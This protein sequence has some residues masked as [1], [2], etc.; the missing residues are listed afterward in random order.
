MLNLMSAISQLRAREILDSRATPTL[1]V[2]ITLEDGTEAR[3]SVPS[4]ASTGKHEAFELRDG[5]LRR[6]GGKGVL[7]SVALVEGEIAS[8]LSGME[9]CEQAQLDANLCALDRALLEESQKDNQEDNNQENNRENNKASAPKSLLGAQAC[10]AVSLACARAA[11]VSLGIP[12]YRHLG[13]VQARTLPVPMMNIINGGAHANNA[14]EVQEFMLLPSGASD[15]SEALRMGVEC[16]AALKSL[17][18]AQGLSNSL[19]DEGGFAPALKSTQQALDLLMQAIEKAGL[20]SGEEITLAIDCAATSYFQ[21]D[22]N[23]TLERKGAK[24][25]E[26]KQG[27][28]LDGTLHDSAS[29]AALL[30]TWVE[31]YPIVS[32][33][34]PFAEDDWHGWS[35][36]T[37]MLGEKIQLVGDDLF[38]SQEERLRQG[39]SRNAGNA[40]LLKP[41]QVGTL[42]E[43]M[44]CGRLALERGW[45]CVVSHR[46]GDTEDSFIADL[47]VGLGCGQ[48]KTGAPARSERVAKY[49][50][51]LR[52]HEELGDEARYRNPFAQPFRSG[53]ECL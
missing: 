27:Y 52:I 42:S 46:S 45:G 19:G 43:A 50:R 12:L 1:E 24:K 30:K 48:I 28:T 29:Y 8:L 41:N 2:A 11:S 34:D 39:F 21:K 22:A 9:A 6:Y 44:A 10:L 47:A 26:S 4:G 7:K 33:E 5:D 49:N 38:V 14:L 25:E 23:S 18:E 51:L 3:A 20:K 31:S 16:Y 37:K 15:F 35:L 13:G 17:L 32:L 36:L 40:L 53:M